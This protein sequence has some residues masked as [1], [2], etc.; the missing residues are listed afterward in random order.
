MNM[1]VAANWV[2][3]QHPVAKDGPIALFETVLTR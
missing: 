1:V 2:Q 3:E